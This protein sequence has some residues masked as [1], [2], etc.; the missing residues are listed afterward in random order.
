MPHLS[1]SADAPD[2][3]GASWGADGMILFEPGPRTGIFRI[4][5]AGG[6]TA[7]VTKLDP[8]QHTTHRWP[9]FLPDGTHFLYLAAN[10]ADP[11]GASTEIYIASLDGKPNASLSGSSISFP[12][13]RRNCSA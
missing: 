5:A 9:N 12:F 11:R 10:N 3:R 4:A 13:T 6:T 2:I 7:P 1:R 8:T